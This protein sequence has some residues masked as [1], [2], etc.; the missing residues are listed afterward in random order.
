MERRRSTDK[1]KRQQE[2]LDLAHI[3]HHFLALSVFVC[4]V[5]ILAFVFGLH[6]G[7]DE[8]NKL[9]EQILEK[10]KPTCRLF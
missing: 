7:I 10:E 1:M 8:Q 9:L 2:E 4:I 6:K 5:T 3:I